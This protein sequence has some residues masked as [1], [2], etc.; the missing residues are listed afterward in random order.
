MK[1][2][3]F[4]II[5]MAFLSGVCFAETDQADKGQWEN[6]QKLKRG[7]KVQVMEVGAIVREGKLKEVTEDQIT[8]EVKKNVIVIPRVDVSR[9]TKKASKTPRILMGLGI[10][11][12][13]G[14][15]ALNDADETS[16]YISS[17]VA[18]PILAG[19]GAGVGA[20]LPVGSVTYQR[21]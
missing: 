14:L 8:I 20:L 17:L 18:L 5:T 16:A 12:A 7:Q 13:I 10:G 9:V 19:G 6:L 15:I 21:P 3:I 2:I 4:G 11:A 1:K